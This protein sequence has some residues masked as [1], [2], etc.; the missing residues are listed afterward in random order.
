MF[1]GFGECSDHDRNEINGLWRVRLVAAKNTKQG[2]PLKRFSRD[3]PFGTGLKPG[4]NEIWH[5]QCSATE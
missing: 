5:T 3:I 1:E 4:V 2:K